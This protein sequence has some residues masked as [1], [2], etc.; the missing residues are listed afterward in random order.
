MTPRIRSLPAFTWG[1]PIASPRMIPSPCPAMRSAIAPPSPYNGTCRRSI[2]VSSLEQPSIARCCTPP[3]PAAVSY[4]LPRWRRASSTNSCT[5]ARAALGIDRYRQRAGGDLA[6]GREALHRVEGN[7][8]VKLGIV[9]NDVA[10][11]AAYVR[12][13]RSFATAPVPNVAGR[14]GAI[15]RHYRGF[16]ALDSL[17]ASTRARM[18]PPG[19]VYGT[20]MC[21]ALRR[22]FP[23]P[24]PRSAAKQE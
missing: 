21:T 1:S 20:M 16:P 2:P 22:E 10:R 7:A 24:A 13:R 9:E 23:A 15:F 6:Y 14:A 12:Q 5:C 19:G 3:L 17:G 18:S 4:K 11:A 8:R